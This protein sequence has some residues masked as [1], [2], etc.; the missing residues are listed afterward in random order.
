MKEY[1]RL[2]AL[3]YLKSNIYHTFDTACIIGTC[4]THKFF[5]C[6]CTSQQVNNRKYLNFYKLIPY[7]V[8]ICVS[9]TERLRFINFFLES[10]T[11]MAT[12]LPI[13]QTTRLRYRGLYCVIRITCKIENVKLETTL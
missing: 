9:I 5:I 6:I 3:V 1:I 13:Y 4:T 10:L 12:T 7:Y 8:N 2:S 11:S